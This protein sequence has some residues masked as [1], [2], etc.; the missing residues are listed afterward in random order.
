MLYVIHGFGPRMLRHRAN[1]LACPLGLEFESTKSPR[2]SVVVVGDSLAIAER[3]NDGH[4][5]YVSK[6]LVPR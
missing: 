2:S 1:S 4:V 6:A 3:G 5:A